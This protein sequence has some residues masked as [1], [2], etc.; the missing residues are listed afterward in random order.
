MPLTHARETLTVEGSI[1]NL[2]RQQLHVL[3]LYVRY[4]DMWFLLALHVSNVLNNQLS[5]ALRRKTTTD[6]INTLIE[7]R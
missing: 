2:S 7:H 1:R 3:A 6:T 4:V 5:A